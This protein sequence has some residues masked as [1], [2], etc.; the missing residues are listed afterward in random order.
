MA[1]PEDKPPALEWPFVVGPDLGGPPR[2]LAPGW[3]A[4][5]APTPQPFRILNRL[6]QDAEAELKAWV[7][8]EAERLREE[9]RRRPFAVAVDRGRD[10]DA[11]V[12][13]VAVDLGDGRYTVEPVGEFGVPALPGLIPGM[14]LIDPVGEIH[15][16]DVCSVESLIV[17]GKRVVVL[18][19]AHAVVELWPDC[20]VTRT[21][22]G[23][24]IPASPNGDESWADTAWHELAHT[25]VAELLD[26]RPSVCLGARS[27]TDERHREETIA[28]ALGR[29]AR[30]IADA[31]NLAYPP[32]LD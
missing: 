7:D 22:D 20:V 18:T 11:T 30:R 8:R 25:L 23:R 13:F 31:I 28:F 2:D 29:H 21:R 10:R 3:Q 14:E 26:N 24:S 6:G 15:K 1:E 12:A 32:K 5:N 9:I 19:F 17:E 4:Q 27:W 16:G